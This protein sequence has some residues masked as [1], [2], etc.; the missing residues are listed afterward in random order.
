MTNL[1]PPLRRK[2]QGKESFILQEV[3]KDTN[4][5]KNLLE[6]LMNYNNNN[7]RVF[8]N[9]LFPFFCV[10]AFHNNNILLIIIIIMGV[11]MVMVKKRWFP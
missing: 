1:G 3:S 2:R 5:C 11:S 7:N 10:L 9:L 4:K 6:L 8:L